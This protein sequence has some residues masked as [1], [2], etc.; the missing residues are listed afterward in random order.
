MADRYGFK[1]FNGDNPPEKIVEKIIY[2]FGPP[3]PTG[4][5]GC[6]GPSGVDG[7]PG[8]AGPYGQ[9]GCKGDKGDLG[10]NG[11]SGQKG[12]KG[13]SGSQGEA[14][15]NSQ[16]FLYSNQSLYKYKLD[17]S[18]ATSG[19]FSLDT[20]NNTLKFSNITSENIDMSWLNIKIVVGNHIKLT[21]YNVRNNFKIVK[22][23]TISYTHTGVK[24]DYT[25]FSSS[26]N[27]IENEYYVMSIEGI[28]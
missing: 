2:K 28:L 9:P 16:P 20:S 14:G 19:Y 4:P 3:G 15:V 21:N 25:E 26:G 18:V 12:M 8:I 6:E 10:C 24:V 13:M 27:F 11:I 5:P 1:K 22:I 7:C 17:H 23:H